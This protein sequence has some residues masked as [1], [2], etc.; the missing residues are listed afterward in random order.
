MQ[1]ASGPTNL[2]NMRRAEHVKI[3]IFL[4]QLLRVPIKKDG[5][6]RPP[7]PLLLVCGVPYKFAAL[8][9]GFNLHPQKVE[10]RSGSCCRASTCDSPPT[11]CEQELS[12]TL[13]IPPFS[14]R[15]LLEMGILCEK[16]WGRG[17]T[18]LLLLRSCFGMIVRREC[19]KI[20]MMHTNR[21]I[22]LKSREIQRPGYLHYHLLSLFLVLAPL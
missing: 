20:Y 13:P 3:P 10:S 22:L 12:T 7:T 6:V 16:S 19:G 14:A 9:Y 4:N 18:F 8:A 11:S 1:H 5:Q 15:C 21:F 2:K 17:D